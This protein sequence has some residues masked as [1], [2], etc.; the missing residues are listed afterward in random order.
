MNV[1]AL[2]GLVVVLISA[3]ALLVLSLRKRTR[4]PSFRQI[5]A[6][7]R[8]NRAIGRSVEEGSRLHISLGSGDL[9]T[10]R[11]APGL[12]GLSVVRRLGTLTVLGDR[13]PV[14][15]AGDAALTLLA[16]DTLRNACHA[17]AAVEVYRPQ[18]GRLT[19]LTPFSYA[20][21]ALPVTRDEDVSVSVLIGNFGAEVALL[22][23][24][25]ERQN[26]FSLAASDALAAQAVLYASAQ[27]TLIGEELFAVGAYIGAGAAHEASLQIQDVLRS[28]LIFAMLSGVLLTLMGLL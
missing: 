28:L 13:P 12:A 24:A 16:Q 15:T 3:G 20:A 19:G 7:T 11:S 4:A 17:A 25:A 14:V 9:I 1:T 27:E 10:P 23:D 21:G 2:A 8:L 6:L 5:P 26:A 18:A 22:T